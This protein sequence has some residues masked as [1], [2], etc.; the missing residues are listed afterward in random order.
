MLERKY[1]YYDATGLTLEESFEVMKSESA[2]YSGDF[3]FEVKDM[4]TI[5][6]SQN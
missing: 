4:T 6:I 2:E 1:A 5:K 3:G